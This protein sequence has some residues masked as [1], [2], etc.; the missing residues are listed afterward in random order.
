MP[1]QSKI[2]QK[3][4]KTTIGLVLCWPTT[5]RLWACLKVQLIYPVRLLLEKTLPI[6]QQ[7]SIAESFLVRGRNLPPLPLNAETPYAFNL[8]AC[9]RT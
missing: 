1:K 2:R 3:V 7:L 5:L 6:H 8:Y 4:F 9:M